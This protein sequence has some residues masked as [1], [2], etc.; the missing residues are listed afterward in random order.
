MQ[1]AAKGVIR[2]KCIALK[3]YV[4]REDG[5]KIS[6]G[7]VDLKRIWEFPLQRRIF[8]SLSKARDRTHILMGTML[9][10]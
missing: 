1:D 7:S 10:C 6:V 8:N 9:G 3:A 5:C 4:R 2:G